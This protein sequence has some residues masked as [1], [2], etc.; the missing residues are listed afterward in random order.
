[1]NTAEIIAVSLSLVAIVFLFL[2]ASNA[3]QQS[4]NRYD[5]MIRRQRQQHKYGETP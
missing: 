2:W 4:K 3:D 5:A 1:M